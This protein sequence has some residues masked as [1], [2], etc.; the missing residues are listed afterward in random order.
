MSVFS[1]LATVVSMIG[2]VLVFGEQI[3]IYDMLGSVMIITGVIG[4][5]VWG[6][7][8]PAPAQAELQKT[9]SHAVTPPSQVR[10]NQ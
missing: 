3:T 4:T 10:A 6:K 5:L 2:G 1:N 7:R 8:K 9:N